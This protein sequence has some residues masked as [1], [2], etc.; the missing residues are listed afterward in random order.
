MRARKKHVGITED[1]LAGY[2]FS[3]VWDDF[4]RKSNHLYVNRSKR[5]FPPRRDEEG[6]ILAKAAG[7]SGE[8]SM[9]SDTHGLVGRPWKQV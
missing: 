4:D 7:E 1:E 5:A 2:R 6:S 3:R 8:G 9:E